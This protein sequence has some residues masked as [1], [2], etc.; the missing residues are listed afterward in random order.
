MF[1]KIE[2]NE[3]LVRAALE[4]SVQMVN[5]VKEEISEQEK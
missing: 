4:L 5:D 2:V 3:S 1:K